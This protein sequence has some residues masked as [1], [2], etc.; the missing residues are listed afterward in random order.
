MISPAALTL[1]KEFH[2]KNS[3][4][5]YIGSA[6][7]ILAALAPLFWIP[8]SRRIGR[9]PVL[10]M[11][12]LI[13]MAGAIGVANSQSFAQ[14]LA[15]RMVMGFG[16]PVG[17]AIAAAAISDMFFQHEKGSRMGFNSLLMVV[18]PYVGG[19]GGGSIQHNENLGWRWAMYITAITYAAEFVLQLFFVPETIYERE[20]A[21]KETPEEK[22]TLARRLGFR[23]PTNPTGESWAKTFARPYIMFVYPAVLLP[24]FW[25]S[26]AVMTEV[27]NTAGFALNFGKASRYH[28]NEAQVGYVFFSGFIGA[29]LGEIVGGPLCDLIAKRSLRKEEEW[30]PERLLKLT[31]SGLLTIVVGLILYGFELEYGTHWAPALLGIVFFVFGQEVVVTVALTYMTDC[32]PA[33]AGEVSVVF[34]FFFNLMCYHPPFYNPMWIAKPYGA[35]VAYLVY[36]LLPA[37]LFPLCI[38]LLIW[39]GPSIR[40]KGALTWRGWKGQPAA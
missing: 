29:A 15:C 27:A 36:A 28:F 33:Q 2:V 8:L 21:A 11:G 19:V 16:G 13:S 17:L 30:R 20:V 18:A 3:T 7:T 35:K 40:A 6:P 25:V 5:T 38:G 37:A 23:T 34:Q 9:R 39:K 10:L 32:Y 22:R 14:A 1:A 12:P 24:S 26:V 31:L 4:A